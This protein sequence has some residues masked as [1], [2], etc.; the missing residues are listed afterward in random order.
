MLGSFQLSFSLMMSSNITNV[1]IY[2][3]QNA[4]SLIYKSTLHLSGESDM[5]LFH[6]LYNKIVEQQVEG[7]H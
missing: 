6:K 7:D 4:G 3:Q 2:N 1:L 5:S